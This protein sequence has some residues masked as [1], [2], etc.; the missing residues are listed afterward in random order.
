M[1]LEYSLQ[2]PLNAIPKQRRILVTG[3]TGYIGSY[4]CKHAACAYDLV[5]MVR[6]GEDAST[7]SG[8]GQVIEADLTNL[9]SLTEAC[10]GVDTVVHLA[11]D[12]SPGAE[13]ESLM[14]NNIEGTYNICVAARDA[15][16][17]RVV[18]ASSV[19]AVSG[20][21]DDVQIKPHDPINP[22]DLY[23][24]S[25]CFG[26]ALGRYMSE[27]EFLSFIAIRIGGVQAESTVPTTDEPGI[28]DSWVSERDIFQLI[29]RSID[30]V[31]LKFAIFSGVSHNRFNR[32]DIT[33]AREL[34]GY[35]PEDDFGEETAEQTS[36]GMTV[37]LT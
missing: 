24:V 28:K 10:A 5:L 7:I 2:T 3:A 1:G 36:H 16:C 34:V 21:P 20:Y 19:H 32:L 17:R 6:P 12:P 25:K 27:R 11:A 8:Y 31:G 22:G 35:E 23:G 29:C 4:F 14:P 15:G 33:T 18:F 13:W 30:V 37:I 9:A 26:E